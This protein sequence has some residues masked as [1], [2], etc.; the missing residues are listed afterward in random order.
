MRFLT[1]VFAIAVIT[2]IGLGSA[3]ADEEA[4]ETKRIREDLIA[5]RN[6]LEAPGRTV[7]EAATNLGTPEAAVGFVR[8]RVAYVPYAG[9]WQDA[10]T[11]LR[12]RAANALD[13]A[14]L[15]EA[16]LKA[17]GKE[18]R[19]IGTAWPAD[20]KPAQATARPIAPTLVRALGAH[21]GG[22]PVSGTSHATLR[23]E[24][25]RAHEMLEQVLEQAGQLERTA[26]ATTGASNTRTP[27]HWTWVQIKDAQGAWQDLDP[28]LP[29]RPRPTTNRYLLTPAP[30]QALVAVL[31]GKK[32]LVAWKGSAAAL[33]QSGAQIMFLPQESKHVGGEN[34]EAVKTWMP[35]L[36][37]AGTTL[38][39]GTFNP[40]EKKPTK[41]VGFGG[42]G[43]LGGG[44]KPAAAGA[45]TIRV[46]VTLLDRMR[47]T[48]WHK[49]LGRDIIRFGKGF[50]PQQLIAVHRVSAGVGIVPYE[51]ALARQID[52]MLDMHDLRGAAMPESPRALRGPSA[53]SAAVMNALSLYQ[54]ALTEREIPLGWNGPGVVFESAML[55]TKGEGIEAVTRI[56]VWHGAFAPTTEA[57]ASDR[58]AWGLA[59]LATEGM[60]MRGP[61]V[62]AHLMAHADAL[63]VL[64][65]A[66]DK[67]RIAGNEVASAVL[68]T[69]GVVIVNAKAPGMTWSITPTGDVLGT[70]ASHGQTAKGAETTSEKAGRG[71]AAL[72][73]A[74]MGGL[75][76]PSGMLVGGIAAYLNELAKAYGGATR[77]LD[78]LS[79]TM[80]TG[81]QKYILEA[82]G[83]YRASFPRD[84]WRA[85]GEGAARGWAESVA[86][87]AAGH[88][89]PSVGSAFGD[90]V[91]DAAVAGGLAY[92]Q[93]LPVVSDTVR[94]A[95]EM[96]MR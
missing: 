87:A 38:T 68:A 6:H 93:D 41:P 52:E 25:T 51:V 23:A 15:L 14:V 95:F 37:V 60:L 47:S 66:S 91:R 21:K 70:I 58:M 20:A 76:A 45:E 74:A 57:T 7:A 96:L 80:E 35:Q 56:D 34:P 17:M 39:N 22:K 30:A 32:Q 79:K 3:R 54:R 12:L 5:L 43:G 92:P 26:G 50:D 48:A 9:S 85:L 63:T 81:D 78:A 59:T 84:M 65:T 40:S 49:T 94:G 16:L 88:V 42:F 36:K 55:A 46:E 19:L 61:S 64:S 28:T 2:S 29:K 31:S 27:V 1:T 72:G 10:D 86:G 90:R 18:T 69:G 8:D 11:V 33:F 13:R 4:T 62:N 82:I 44:A 67:A 89:L 24:V 77:V 53:R 83:Q 73:G 75:G 71:F